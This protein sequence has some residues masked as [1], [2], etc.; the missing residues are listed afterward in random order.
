M[1]FCFKNIITTIKE[2]KMKEIYQKDI[3]IEKESKYYKILFPFLNKDNYINWDLLY[4]TIMG[5]PDDDDDEDTFEDKLVEDEVIDAAAK[6]GLDFYN[7]T[8]PS[9]LSD[10]MLEKYAKFICWD[11]ASNE[12]DLSVDIILKYKKYINFDELSLTHD[13]T[14][15]FLSRCFKFI[16]F[17]EINY[18]SKEHCLENNS[19][20]IYKLDGKNLNLNCKILNKLKKLNIIN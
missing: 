3:I 15:E 14:E 12:E 11:F 16:N 7:I 2:E 9:R 5:G 4:D 18:N 6:F 13:L 19:D 20:V 17:D 10:K 1:K 8:S